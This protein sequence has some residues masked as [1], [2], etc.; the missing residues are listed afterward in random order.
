M[1]GNKSRQVIL[2]PL[3]FLTNTS[4]I[5][6]CDRDTIIRLSTLIR[7][8]WLHSQTADTLLPSQTTEAITPPFRPGAE[9]RPPRGPLLGRNN[10]SVACGM[11]S[12][13]DRE[14]GVCV[15]FGQ[16][17]IVCE[18]W[19]RECPGVYQTAIRCL[20]VSVR[21]MRWC[22]WVSAAY[23]SEWV[24]EWVLR[25]WVSE[26]VEYVCDRREGVGAEW[27]WMSECTSGE[28]RLPSTAHPLSHA[29]PPA[30]RQYIYVLTTLYHIHVC[31]YHIRITYVYIECTW[32]HPYQDLVASGAGGVEWPQQH[33]PVLGAPMRRRLTRRR[34]EQILEAGDH[35]LVVCLEGEREENGQNDTFVCLEGGRAENN[36]P[37]QCVGGH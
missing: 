1:F 20:R 9:A 30:H 23:V 8:Q 17:V 37:R 2:F 16:G 28:W 18:A 13:A 11:R 24:S 14:E 21:G 32:L 10:T 19:V 34:A 12:R 33:P 36:R 5:P 31:M 27:W 22:R 29:P 26:W 4:Q 6:L 3:G 35:P 7:R 15:G 25:M